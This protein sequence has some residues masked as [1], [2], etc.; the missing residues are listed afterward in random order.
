[1]WKCSIL[2]DTEHHLGS[3]QQVG[4]LLIGDST[5]L[6]FAYLSENPCVCPHHQHQG[7]QAEKNILPTLKLT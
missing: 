5:V 4:T 3:F 2:S 6:D 7:F 1:M